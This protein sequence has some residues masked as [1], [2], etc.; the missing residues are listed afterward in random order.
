MEIGET[1]PR[2]LARARAETVRNH[3]TG[4]FKTPASHLVSCQPRPEPGDD[5]AEPRTDLLL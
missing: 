4:T 2:A 3:P 1:Q 5:K